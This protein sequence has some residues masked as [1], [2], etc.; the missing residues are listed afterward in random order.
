MRECAIAIP[1]EETVATEES[2]ESEGQGREYGE[3]RESREVEIDERVFASKRS[4]SVPGGAIEES[5]ERERETI[6][7]LIYPFPPQ[8]SLGE[9]E[10]YSPFSF[11]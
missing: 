8:G 10:C 5:E 9:Y 1:S 2:V 3:W 7:S 4:V 6:G 11:F